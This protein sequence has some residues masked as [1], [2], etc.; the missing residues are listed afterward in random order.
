M[1]WGQETS[2]G[3]N[4]VQGANRA[5]SFPG[6]KYS[7]TMTCEL[8]TLELIHMSGREGASTSSQYQAAPAAE[9][10]DAPPNGISAVGPS[11][12]L[13][14]WGVSPNKCRECTGIDES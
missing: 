12:V 9:S 2:H 7:P 3:G 5:A 8:I 1:L 11:V 4:H 10:G 6:C 14:G 13:G